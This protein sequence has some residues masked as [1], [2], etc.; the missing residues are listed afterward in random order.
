M[1]A[2]IRRILAR[3]EIPAIRGI[4]PVGWAAHKV[5]FDRIVV[6]VI[7]MTTEIPLIPDDVIPVS[8]LPDSPGRH[9]GAL[10]NQTGEG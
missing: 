4:T 8:P 1:F 3:F 9:S 5:V 10:R 7:E 6:Y 2:P